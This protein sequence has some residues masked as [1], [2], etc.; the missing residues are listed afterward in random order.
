MLL[1]T[2]YQEK[3]T[4]T[5]D[6][7][8]TK[9]LFAILTTL[10]L[11][12][13][14]MGKRLQQL[15]ESKPSQ[16]H[17]YKDVELSRSED[18]KFSELEGDVGKLRKTHNNVSLHTAAGKS[19]QVNKKP[20]TN[21]N[22]NNIFD[23]PITPKIPKETMTTTPQT[24]TYANSLHQNKKIYNHITQTYIENIYKIQTFLNLNPRAT[25]TT[26]PTQD[27]ITQKL[28]GYNR[29]IAQPK[30]RSN[31]VKTCY[32]YGLLST[33]Y[34]YD[35]EEISGIP[36]IYKAF[37]TYKRITKGN[38]FF[39]KFYTAPAEILYDEIKPVIQVVKIGLTRDMLIPEEIEQQPEIPKIEIP[40]FYANKRIIGITTIIQELAN[41]YLQENAIW[42][43]YS[44]DQLM[45]YATSTQIIYVQSA[46]EKIIMYQ[47]YNWNKD[48][49]I[50]TK[51]DKDSRQLCTVIKNILRK[52]AMSNNAE[53][54]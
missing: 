42:S 39:I 7:Q 24:S 38:L 25:T 33:V 52:L 23:K 49:S 2:T 15:Q 3:G 8:E 13:D 32:N 51:E 44:R 16:Q 17:D 28:Q 50:K 36:E 47:K 4:Q 30:T 45:I 1:Q 6:R 46:M 37:I 5:D 29:L 9:D 35:G 54:S 40:S 10:S 31:L 43:Y 21:A 48:T 14:S 11:H 34:T 41:N 27:Y 26:N 19:K 18:S 53:S 22:L 12:M 20:Y